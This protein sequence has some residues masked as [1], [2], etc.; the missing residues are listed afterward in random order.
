MSLRYDPKRGTSV[1]LAI[2]YPTNASLN[3]ETN[4]RFTRALVDIHD[5]QL[6]VSKLLSI[7]NNLLKRPG[8]VY[9]P[10][11]RSYPDASTQDFPHHP[12]IPPFPHP[13][14]LRLWH[15]R[16]VGPSA[17]RARSKPK[18]RAGCP[19]GGIAIREKR[20]SC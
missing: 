14:S 11:L 5:T 19:I 18:R 15:I 10:Y 1:G 16:L 9:T 3:T 13:I 20:K 4:V 6:N 2:G 7:D 17:S 12:S 8:Y